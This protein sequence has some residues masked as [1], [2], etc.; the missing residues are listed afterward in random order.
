MA[1]LELI[2][3]LYFRHPA[4]LGASVYTM[5]A[6]LFWGGMPLSLLILW[7]HASCMHAINANPNKT[8]GNWVKQVA[9]CGHWATRHECEFSVCVRACSL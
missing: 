5:Q 3:G 9:V 2:R 7:K 8:K 6:H 4:L 1:A